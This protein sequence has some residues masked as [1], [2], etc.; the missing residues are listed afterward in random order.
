MKGLPADV[1]YTIA[2]DRSALI[3]RA[4]KT[5]EEKLI[6]ESIVVAL[7]CLLFLLHF[8]SALVAIV[9]LPSRC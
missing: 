4:V 5:L 8:R 1:S 2:Y 3:D 9:I 7:V 6:E